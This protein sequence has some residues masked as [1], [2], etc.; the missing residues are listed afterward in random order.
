MCICVYAHIHHVSLASWVA[1]SL[2]KL[3]RFHKQ[4]VFNM[5]MK[6]KCENKR[7]P[8]ALMGGNHFFGHLF[9]IFE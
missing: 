7:I 1:E 4:W 5:K 3:S 9:S 2:L 6:N 8:A